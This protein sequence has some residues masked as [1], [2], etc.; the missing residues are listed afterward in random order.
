MSRQ[1]VT[2][3]LG[4]RSYPVIV[5]AGVRVELNSVLPVTARRAVIVTQQSIP[6]QVETDIPSTTVVIGDGEQHK[7]SLIHI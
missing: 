3:Q 6:I 7:L 4:E 1:Q 5:G 2:V